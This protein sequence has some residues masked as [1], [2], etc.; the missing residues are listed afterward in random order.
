MRAFST[1][2]DVWNHFHVDPTN[3][4]RAICRICNK[5][6]SRDGKS[7]NTTNLRK[8]AISVHKIVFRKFRVDLSVLDIVTNEKTEVKIE[9]DPMPVLP[10][11]SSGPCN[12]V[13]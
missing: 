3:D 9:D 10:K 5:S 8:H 4:S 12:K 1:M 13:K 7:H 6:F 11:V 2:S